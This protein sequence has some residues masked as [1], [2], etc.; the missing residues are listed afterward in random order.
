MR[1]LVDSKGYPTEL[2]GKA[3]RLLDEIRSMPDYGRLFDHFEDVISRRGYDP[4]RSARVHLSR[5]RA[6]TP[7]LATERSGGMERTW[8]ELHEAGELRAY[9]RHSLAREQIL[10]NRPHDLERA[11]V[12]GL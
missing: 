11:R 5:L 6:I 4:N 1:P 10:L 9:L 8:G 3:R 2:S 12:V 7:L